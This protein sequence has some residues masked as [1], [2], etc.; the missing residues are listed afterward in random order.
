MSG[1]EGVTVKVDPYV[2]VSVG[3]PMQSLADATLCK[4]SL[5]LSM[6][7][8]GVP[9]PLPLVD[10][11]GDCAA[12]DKRSGLRFHLFLSASLAN[13]SDTMVCSFSLSALSRDA[14]DRYM[15]RPEPVQCQGR[16]LVCLF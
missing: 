5:K 8:G 12:H 7:L 13:F 4:I 11:M 15:L 2:P 14:P 16:V 6:A 9:L 3:C 10:N 1:L